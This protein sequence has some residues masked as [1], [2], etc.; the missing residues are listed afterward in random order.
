MYM[1]VHCEVY[2]VEL[3]C[4]GEDWS[5]INCMYYVA[6]SFVSHMQGSRWA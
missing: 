1:Y 4:R 3:E 6:L 2:S 5:G